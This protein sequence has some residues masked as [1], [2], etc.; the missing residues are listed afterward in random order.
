VF[1]DTSLNPSTDAITRITD[2]GS[3]KV[4]GFGG[5]VGNLTCSG[6]DNDRMISK[7]ETYL[8]VSGGGAASMYHLSDNG[9]QIQVV[10]SGVVPG[11][12][13]NCPMTTS[14]TTDTRFYYMD[15]TVQSQIWQGDITSDSTFTATQLVDLMGAGVCP[16]ITSFT[17]TGNSILS[18][19]TDDDTFA[20]VLA[21]GGQG[22]GDWVIAWS[23]TKGC[24]TVNFNTG[25]AWG[26]CIS[27][28][29]SST[30]A[31]GTMANG[32]T[33]CWGSNGG[34]N[35]GVHDVQMNGNG[36]WMTVAQTG[37]WTQGGCNGLSLSGY[38]E[39]QPNSTNN[40]WCAN[41]GGATLNCGAHQSVGIEN[42]TTPSFNG[43]NVRD[44]A[45][46]A[47]YTQFLTAPSQFDAHGSWP[48]KCSGSLDDTCPWI[49]G[50]DNVLVTDSTVGSGGCTS[51]VFCPNW[52][53]NM[54]YATFPNGTYPPGTTP[55]LFTHT[56]AC[57]DISN[58][59][60][61]Q[62]PSGINDAFGAGESI[63][64]ASPNGD[65]FCWVSSM[66][67]NMGN[68]NGGANSPRADAF[69]VKLQ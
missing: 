16:G 8:F 4:G 49:L 41:K 64:L 11:V 44:M 63:G 40:Q 25:Q 35:N 47:S 52:L 26:W 7:N 10:N 6:G 5:S 42:M 12:V 9:T 67:Q 3:V 60:H 68:D 19:T 61:A 18:L 22:S 50:A 24:S 37:T 1:H 34:T 65:K 20:V 54:I 30:P 17:V 39:W 13:V 58:V 2:G 48:H 38:A 31:L 21:P 55:R 15:A 36:T 27:G 51:G 29:S 69:C 43:Y 46:V 33:N 57:P 23:K 14:W 53:N 62:C 28:C 59:S 32:S 45:N 66:L 56:Y